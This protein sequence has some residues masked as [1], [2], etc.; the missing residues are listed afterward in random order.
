LLAALRLLVA[1]MRA[2]TRPADALSAAATMDPHHVT[3]WQRAADAQ[4][5]GSGA[6]T[7]LCHDPDLAFVGHAWAVA[8]ATG[9]APAEVLQKAAADV[10]AHDEHCRAVHTALAGA[11]ASAAIMAVLPALG[12]VLGTAMGARPI[13]TLFGTA[14]GRLCLVVGIAFDAAGLAWTARIARR[15]SAA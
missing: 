1:E 12:C 3:A 8:A 10:A 11:R 5:A 7:V 2:G 15:A 9:A 13:P 6:A 14:A 4:R